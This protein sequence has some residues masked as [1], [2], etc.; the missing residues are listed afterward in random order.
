MKLRSP[1]RNMISPTTSFFVLG[2]LAKVTS[3]KT[4]T[5][6]QPAAA[7]TDTSTFYVGASNGSLPQ[8]ATVPGLV[9]DRFIQIWLENTDY[10]AAAAQPAFQT[11]SQEGITLSG[12]YALTHP[13]QP[14][15]IAA[16][17]GSF[18]GLASDD[19][20]TIPANVSTIADLLDAKGITWAEYEENMPTDGYLGD[21][22]T[23]SDG[24]TYYMRKH[25]PLVSYDTVNQNPARLAR[26]RNFNDFAYDVGNNTLPQWFFVTPNMKDDGHDTGVAY[27]S[28]WL[29][30]WLVPLL[31]DTNFNTPRTLILLTFDENGNYA[32]NNEIYSILLGGAVPSNL[33]GTVDNTFYTHYSTLSTVQNNWSLDNL[34]QGDC[35]ATLAN[36]FQFV[37]DVTGYKNNGMTNGT[38]LPLFNITGTIPGP[39]N[40]SYPAPWPTPDTSCIGAGGGGFFRSK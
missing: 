18:W 19:E 29:N 9:F 15:Y 33:K 37:A 21:S 40:P 2:A 23:N 32:I 4:T 39:L 1:G 35:N 31:Q 22:F 28:D 38:N 16:A 36:V 30:Y 8:T 27:A 11:L 26:L 13:S 14:N 10:S 3:A 20:V 7:P 34:G 12:Y 5:F 24:Y 17:G 25:S 6:T